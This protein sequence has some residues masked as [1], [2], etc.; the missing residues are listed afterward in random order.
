MTRAL[1]DSPKKTSR[2]VKSLLKTYWQPSKA[3]G[4]TVRHHSAPSSSAW[5]FD[6]GCFLFLK[7]FTTKVYPFAQSLLYTRAW[8]HVHFTITVCFVCEEKSLVKKKK[9]YRVSRVFSQNVFFFANF[10]IRLKRQR[11]SIFVML[12]GCRLDLI[13]F[14]GVGMS[15]CRDFSKGANKKQCIFLNNNKFVLWN[16]NN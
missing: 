12:S 10:K 4:A 13:K 1:P 2:E 16:T 11:R 8:V 9:K 7:L 15:A 6:G 5:R 3:D 14:T